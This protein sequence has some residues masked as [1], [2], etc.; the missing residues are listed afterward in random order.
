MGYGRVRIMN[1]L[2]KMPLLDGAYG[3]VSIELAR[4]GVPLVQT[5]IRGN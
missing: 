3:G 4:Y 1:Q 2:F 5:G